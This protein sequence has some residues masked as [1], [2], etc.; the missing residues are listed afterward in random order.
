MVML[1]MLLLG[2]G[3]LYQGA[4]TVLL[5]WGGSCLFVAVHIVTPLLCLFLTCSMCTPTKV[6]PVV[7]TTDDE[8]ALIQ[9][10]NV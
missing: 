2:G 1:F 4:V 5:E 6:T 9:K 8:K 3:G 10:A 7:A